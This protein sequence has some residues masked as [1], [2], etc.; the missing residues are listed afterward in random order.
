MMSLLSAKDLTIKFGGLTAVSGFNLDIDE[1][2]I[3]EYAID[4]EIIYMRKQA[5][6]SEE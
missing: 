5:L 3:Y 6:E 2:E 4:F 1:N